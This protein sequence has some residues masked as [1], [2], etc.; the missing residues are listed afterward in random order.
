MEL[1]CIFAALNGKI[2]YERQKHLQDSE[3]NP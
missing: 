1:F 3:G 2:D